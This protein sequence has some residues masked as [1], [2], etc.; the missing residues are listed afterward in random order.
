MSRKQF[1]K[2]SAAGIN[3]SMERVANTGSIA[4]DYAIHS[5]QEVDH[6]LDANKAMATH[7]DGYTPSRE[8]RRAA[9]IPYSLIEHWRITEGWNAWDASHDPDVALK[10][11]QKLNSREYQHLRTA[12]GQLSAKS[13]EIR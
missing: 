12:D 1:L 13:G 7:N 4:H 3:W 2:T 5:H 10:L 9:S 8:M 6:I 11:V